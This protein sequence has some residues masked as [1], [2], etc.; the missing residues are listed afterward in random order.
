[1]AQI[2]STAVVDA[3][4]ELAASVVVGPYAVIG[5][6]V[7]IGPGTTVGPHCVI[8]GRTTIG[9]DNRFFQFSSI[10]AASQDIWQ[11]ATHR[12]TVTQLEI[13]DRNTIREFC[14]LNTGTF[15][16]EGITRVGSDNWIMA[17]V[18][19]AHDVQLGS[20]CVL[21]NGVTFAGHVHVGD[22]ATIGG[23]TGVLQ[24][25]HIGAHAM[26]GFQANVDLD[27]PPYLTVDGNPL[28]VRAVNL[29]GLKRRDFSAERLSLIRQMHKLLYRSGL[30]LDQAVA[31]IAA[32]KGSTADGD[33]D[34]QV[35]LDFL[36]ASKRGIAR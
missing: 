35:M 30:P 10:G 22:W 11:D 36:A 32:L 16:E 28:A 33:V 8:E 12:G 17:Y 26:V 1:M 13:G 31:G 6:E 29:V 21:A 27:V 18:H 9:R 34:V 14:T 24:Y 4:A 15:K 20:H 23:L 5:P 7:R 25:V 2:H 3:G 19:V